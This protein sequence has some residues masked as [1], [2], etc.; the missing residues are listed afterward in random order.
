[1]NRIF[2]ETFPA[3]TD[4]EKGGKDFEV[5][6]LRPIKMANAEATI[7]MQINTR[8]GG[9]KLKEGLVNSLGLQ[10]GD[11]INAEI[12][13]LKRPGLIDDADDVDLFA[14]GVGAD[15]LLDNNVGSG[16]II[17]A[18]VKFVYA[19]APVGGIEGREIRKLSLVLI[20]GYNIVKERSTDD[21]HISSHTVPTINLSERLATLFG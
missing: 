3:D 9:W 4:L 10:V 12:S 16:S 13:V 19:P 11:T 21:E 20:E 1:M 18:K 2:D 8:W 15:W 7:R 17:D 5:F 14:S 6:W